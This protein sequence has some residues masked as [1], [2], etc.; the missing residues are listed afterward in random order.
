MELIERER[1]LRERG[2]E[3]RAGIEE[4]EESDEV[5]VRE[6]VRSR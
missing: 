2:R 5:Q 4:G 3:G 6:S 1:E